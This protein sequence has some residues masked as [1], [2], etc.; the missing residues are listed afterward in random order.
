MYTN[1]MVSKGLGYNLR[2]NHVRSVMSMLGL[3]FVGTSRV[4][5]GTV[6]SFYGEVD[7]SS[8]RELEE[9]L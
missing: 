6:V 1:I 2:V 8:L 5:G 7:D 4:K 9:F 3:E